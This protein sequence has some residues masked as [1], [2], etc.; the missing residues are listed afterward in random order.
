MVNGPTKTKD[1]ANFWGFCM[2]HSIKGTKLELQK[3][4]EMFFVGPLTIIQRN[5][6][7]L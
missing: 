4:V 6:I 7:F 5:F 1:S 2:I 3:L